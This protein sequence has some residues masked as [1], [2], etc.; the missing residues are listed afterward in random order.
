[1]FI[2]A[3]LENHHQSNPQWKSGVA[4]L[5]FRNVVKPG[6]KNPE[7]FPGVLNPDLNSDHNPV[8][9]T[10]KC[11]S[12]LKTGSWSNFVFYRKSNNAKPTVV[13]RFRQNTQRFFKFPPFSRSF[14]QTPLEWYEGNWKPGENCSLKQLG[15]QKV[16]DC[17][18]KKGKVVVVGDSR[19]RSLSLV[20]DHIYLYP[21]KTAPI[22]KINRGETDVQFTLRSQMEYLEDERLVKYVR[23]YEFVET[24]AVGVSGIEDAIDLINNSRFKT[25]ALIISDHVLH[26]IKI[27]ARLS[28]NFVSGKNKTQLQ[29]DEANNVV[30]SEVSDEKWIE[31]TVINPLKSMMPKFLDLLEKNP[32]LL[33]IFLASHLP[34]RRQQIEVHTKRYIS[35]YNTEVRKV[36]GGMNHDRILFMDVVEKL[37]LSPT[38]LSLAVDGTHLSTW[39]DI[40]YYDHIWPSQQNIVEIIFNLVC[41][42]KSDD[43]HS[44]FCCG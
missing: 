7:F 16:T 38:G 39:R 32:D 29:I 9:I 2:H 14:A 28:H 41:R 36:I 13:Q 15:F 30:V 40:I 35:S 5:K 27:F 44:K 25:S 18:D 31:K 6:V 12:T 20:M 10:K 19:A 23:S 34:Y 42:S 24:D 17:I 43:G 21:N 8:K 11:A 1:M 37:G 33:V 4:V 26:P 3:C 22:T